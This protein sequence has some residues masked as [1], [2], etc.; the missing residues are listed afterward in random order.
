MR[1]VFVVAWH[2]PA[3]VMLHGGP[4]GETLA[5]I[6]TREGLK[7]DEMRQRLSDCGVA[8]IATP[9]KVL[10]MENIPL[11][12][13]GKVDYVTLEEVLKAKGEEE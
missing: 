4:R 12:S 7:R 11:L 10:I 3:V 9:K 1:V 13:T 6:T 5:L 8:E 2:K